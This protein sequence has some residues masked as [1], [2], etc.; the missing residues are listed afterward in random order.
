MTGGGGGPWAGPRWA[1]R[2]DTA[3][4]AERAAAG[5]IVTASVC[6]NSRS[7]TA[8]MMKLPTARMPRPEALIR[9]ESS[10]Q[11]SRVVASPSAR[12]NESERVVKVSAG[13]S[14]FRSMAPS[15]RG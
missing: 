6:C 14:E 7:S 1:D 3:R 2:S 15:A 10:V 13:A 4:R 11:L 9:S 5:L 12:S 8:L